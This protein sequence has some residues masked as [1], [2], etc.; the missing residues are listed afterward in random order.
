VSSRIFPYPDADPK[1]DN[2]SLS[3]VRS[4]YTPLS[5]GLE[6]PADIPLQAHFIG[7]VRQVSPQATNTTY[8][9]D[10]GT[11]VI[12]VKQWVDSD[13]AED[14]EK[15]VPKEGDYIHVFG[16][17]KEFNNKRH[18]APQAIRPITDFNENYHLLNA[19]YVHLYFTRGPP[20][21]AN[22][23]V[24]SEGQGL[25]VDGSG[26]AP[27]GVGGKKLPAGMSAMAKR[28]Y[29]FLNNSPQNN[30]GLHVHEIARQLNVPSNEVFKSGDE[31]ILQGLIYTTIDDETWAVLE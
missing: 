14:D 31:L 25:F 21:Q 26:G 7:Q 12:D 17:L 1:I 27:N 4:Y 28:V 3:Q 11:S 16:K 15:Y 19:T 2:A 5:I 8:K 10:D 9:V 24:K 22:G 18:V 13:A 6:L 23:A 20:G 30:E 29:E